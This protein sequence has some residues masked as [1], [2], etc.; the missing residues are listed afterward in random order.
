[1]HVFEFKFSVTDG[2]SLST[3]AKGT[4][5][6]NTMGLYYECTGTSEYKSYNLCVGSVSAILKNNISLAYNDTEIAVGIFASN[7][8]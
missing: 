6:N 8:Y 1:M 5:P 7:Y 2:E 4:F 3:I